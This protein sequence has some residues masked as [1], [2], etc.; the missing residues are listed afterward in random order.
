MG[1]W[2]TANKNKT[3]TKVVIAGKQQ[4]KLFY[5]DQK[6][7]KTCSELKTVQ[8]KLHIPNGKLADS[9]QKQNNNKS[10]LC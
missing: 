3:T 4:Y 6:Q 10:C 1:I 7:E 2:R 8:I 9:K 5:C